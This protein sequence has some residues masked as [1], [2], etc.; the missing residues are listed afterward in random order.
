MDWKRYH[1]RVPP[2]RCAS[3][4]Q[5]VSF[6]AIVGLIEH[7]PMEVSMLPAFFA[8]FSAIYAQWTLSPEDFYPLSKD[9]DE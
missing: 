1:S 4:H 8:A 2:A 7:V 3:A 5:Q 9:D 6:L